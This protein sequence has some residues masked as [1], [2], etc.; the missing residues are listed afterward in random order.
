MKIP[1]WD[2]ICRVLKFKLRDRN[3]IIFG[4]GSNLGDRESY[5][6]QARAELTKQLSLTN[7]KT[8]NILKNPA[9][10]LP[11]SP[12]EWNIEFFNQ[13]FSADINLEKFPPEKILE[14]VNTIEKNLGRIRRE[15]W[16]PREID[17][18]I[19]AIDNL[20]IN[21][22]EKLIIP[23]REMLNRDFVIKTVCEIEEGMLKNLR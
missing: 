11:N 21:L 9:L 1:G 18:D 16:A 8:S 17:I 15:K 20:K 13:A 14:I 7:P 10:L 5:L 2:K 22:G 12:P 6:A 19:L 4:L 3:R 23:H